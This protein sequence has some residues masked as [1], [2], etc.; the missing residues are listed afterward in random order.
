[1]DGT[2][3]RVFPEVV[4]RQPNRSC[5]IEFQSVMLHDCVSL[6]GLKV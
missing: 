2:V 1:M 3:S 6:Q 4:K 5:P